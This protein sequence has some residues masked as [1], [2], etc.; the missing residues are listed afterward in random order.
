MQ[1]L[2]LGA[3]FCHPRCMFRVPL[4]CGI[5]VYTPCLEPDRGKWAIFHFSWGYIYIYSTFARKQEYGM[6]HLVQSAVP[7]SLYSSINVSLNPEPS[8]CTS[9]VGS[10]LRQIW[11]TFQLPSKMYVHVMGKV[12]PTRHI[13]SMSSR[14]GVPWC[15]YIYTHLECGSQ[16]LTLHDVPHSDSVYI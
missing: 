13:Q 6:S 10:T 5:C 4:P 8:N 14:F 2:A 12:E 7:K 1:Q 3:T 11:C 16:Q 9:L 15:Y